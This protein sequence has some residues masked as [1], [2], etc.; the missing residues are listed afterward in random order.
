MWVR[1][2]LAPKSQAVSAEAPFCYAPRM[3]DPTRVRESLVWHTYEQLPSAIAGSALAVALLAV[4]VGLHEGGELLW[5]W[6]PVQ[7]ASHSLNLALYLAYRAGRVPKS[8]TRALWLRRAS[9]MATGLA[10]GLAGFLWPV[11]DG[12]GPWLG[13]VMCLGGILAG[14]SSTIAADPKGYVGLTVVMIA[15]AVLV[16]PPEHWWAAALLVAFG[17]ATTFVVIRN[18]RVLKQ[19]FALRWENEELLAS[20]LAQGQAAEAARARA[21]EADEAKTRFLAAA[22]HDLRQPVQA[23][24]LFSDVLGSDP[25]PEARQRATEAIHRS[26]K[27]LQ[28]MLEGLLDISRLDSGL[29]ATAPVRIC[30]DSLFSEVVAALADEADLSDMV[31][32]SAGPALCVHA[33]NG[34]LSRVIHN[35]ATNAVRH[36]GRGRVLLSARR[37]GEHALVQVWDQGRGIPEKDC[38][39]IFDEFV[40]LQNSERDRE[41]GLGL[42]LSMV[43]RICTLCGWEL[44]LRSELGRG[45]V[46][47]VR[48][49]LAESELPVRQTP[50]SVPDARPRA[51]LLVEDDQLVRDALTDWVGAQGGQA[52]T[53]QNGDEAIEVCERSPAFDVVIADYRLP[54]EHT[55]LE[56]IERIR[57]LTGRSMPSILL[58]GDLEIPSPLLGETAS[59]TVLTKPVTGTKLSSAI[60]RLVTASRG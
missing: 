25:A 55:G 39:R 31:I 11:Q 53:A 22:S 4:G 16:T 42:G 51:F 47:S 41:Q 10:W 35:L 6:L 2:G 56:V 36:G 58:S 8:A 7:F 20:A 13:T 27:A 57:R 40:Q 26:T 34:L 50:L 38:E 30:L 43:R 9:S 46:F 60:D 33:D 54:G 49:P 17:A 45:T 24:A 23:L 32:S 3:H 28:A 44:E 21:E 52:Y 12:Y 59:L 1:V 29:V 19:S 14:A 48:L 5:I 15:P 18:S 37:R